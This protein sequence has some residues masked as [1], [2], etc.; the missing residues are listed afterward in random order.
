MEPGAGPVQSRGMQFS[1]S[2]S[3]PPVAGVLAEAVTFDPGVVVAFFVVAVLVAVSAAAVVVVGIVVGYRSGRD[4]TLDLARRSW[5]CCLTIESA[6]VAVAVLSV[7]PTWILI[8]SGAVAASVLA[9][10]LGR[11]RR[12]VGAPDTLPR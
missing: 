10:A 11:A 9:R 1:S 8:T 6:L 3:S 7:A 12:P 4:D 5:V 2:S